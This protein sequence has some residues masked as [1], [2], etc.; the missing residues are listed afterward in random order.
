MPFTDWLV[1]GSVFYKTMQ[2]PIQY[3]SRF[4]QFGGFQYTTAENFPSGSLLGIELES[5]VTMGPILGEEW[6]GLK[7]GANF[8]YMESQVELPQDQKDAWALYGLPQSTQ[9]M[10]QTPEF[11]VNLNATYD[12]EPTGTQVGLFYNYRGDAL[13]SGGVPN[14]VELTPAIYQLGYGTLNFTMS[15]AI[16]DGLRFSFNAKNLLNPV[17]TT[18]YQTPNGITGLNSSY[19]AGIDFSIALTYQIAF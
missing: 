14:L 7:F 10:T 8:T 4:A 12:H 19:T 9:Q 5:R 18:Q 17:I 16:F 3:I 1:S 2:D 13:V 15:Q 11:L 6:E